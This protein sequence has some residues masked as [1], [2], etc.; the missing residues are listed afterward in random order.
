MRV[1]LGL[2]FL[3]AMT[4]ALAGGA[5]AADVRGTVA[6][7]SVV[8]INDGS[9]A[10]ARTLDMHNRDRQFVPGLIV[11]R[12]GQAVRFPND[13]AF[14]HSIYSDSPSNPFD[15]GYYG[16]GP[17]KVIAFDHPG[18]VEVR[19]HIHFSMHG[20]IVVTEGPY[21]DG[22]VK[23]FDLQNVAPGTHTLFVRD[24]K[25]DLKTKTLTIPAGPAK[26]DLGQ[27]P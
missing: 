22:L 4:L 15:I 18:I 19:C 21:T 10:P 8:W 14:Y 25:G 1:F 27:V 23:S 24:E 5:S 20:V 11:V 13:D 9:Q 26:I 12:T 2:S 3:A 7:P 17:G 6:V 16:T